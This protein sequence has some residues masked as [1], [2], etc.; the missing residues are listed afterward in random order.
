MHISNAFARPVYFAPEGEGGTGEPPPEGDGKPAGEGAGENNID[1]LPE[2]ARAAITKA[3]KEAAGFRTKVRELEPLAKKAQEL[4]D[5]GKSD[6]DKLNAR[7]ADAEKR[8]QE[9]ELRVLRL[10]V[11]ADK[12]LSPAQARRLVGGT[13]E[14]LEEDADDLLATFGGSKSDDADGTKPPSRRPKE[15]LKA[16]GEPEEEPEPDTDKILAKVPRL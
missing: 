2:W 16:G 6:A 13:K 3:N 1:D 10:E 9:A 15:R 14:E 5:A 11:A 4:E 12:G 8:A 7:A